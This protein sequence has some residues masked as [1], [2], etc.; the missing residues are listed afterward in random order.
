MKILTNEEAA[1]AQ[2][3][4]DY[5]KEYRKKNRDKI[6]QSK[7]IWN[8]EN[9]E[10]LKEYQDRYWTKRANELKIDDDADDGQL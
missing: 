3:R 6:N 7:R 8:S 4:R 5:Q 2:A 9:K 10:K 1:A